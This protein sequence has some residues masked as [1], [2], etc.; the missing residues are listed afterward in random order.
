[1]DFEKRGE[2]PRVI[3]TADEGSSDAVDREADRLLL[4]SRLDPQPILLLPS[5]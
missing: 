5:D 4:T 2:A 1:M 3:T